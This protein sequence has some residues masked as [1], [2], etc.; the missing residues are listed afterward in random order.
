VTPS[1]GWFLLSAAAAQGTLKFIQVDKED[2]GDEKGE[3]LAEQQPA[4]NGQTKGLARVPMRAA[5]VVIMIG[6]NRIRQ[7]S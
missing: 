7:A 2:R 6:L 3:E 1:E 4:Y 5:M